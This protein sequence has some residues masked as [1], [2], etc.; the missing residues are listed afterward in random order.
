MVSDDGTSEA[1]TPTIAHQDEASGSSVKY[2]LKD[3]EGF[4][5]AVHA[6]SLDEDSPKNMPILRKWI[7]VFVISSSALCV[8]CTSSIVSFLQV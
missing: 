8:A 3:L 4:A 1:T 5:T 2:S 7:V 6:V